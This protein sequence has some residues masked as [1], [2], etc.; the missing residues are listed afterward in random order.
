MEITCGI[1]LY[2]VKAGKFL[3]GHAARTR[4]NNWSIPKGLKDPGESELE[5]AL[6]ELNE[7]TGINLK[8]ENILFAFSLS[9]S[10][11][12]TRKKILNAFLI[13]TDLDP[14]ILELSCSSLV[15]DE[16]PEIDKFKWVKPEE[17]SEYI[18]ESQTALLPEIEELLQN[19]R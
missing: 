11:Y 17:M 15:N 16:Y 8:P 3:I 10:M 12:K 5:A 6:R 18:H 4:K 14:E 13:I 2:S 7:E 9:P 19:V 1:F